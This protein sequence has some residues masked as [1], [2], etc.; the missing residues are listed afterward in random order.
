MGSRATACSPLHGAATGCNRTVICAGITIPQF[1][2]G[3]TRI[4]SRT[5][6]WYPFADTV[7][8]NIPAAILLL[9]KEG[10]LGS[11]GA[12]GVTFAEIVSSVVPSDTRSVRVDDG[13]MPVTASTTVILTDGVASAKQSPEQP[14]SVATATADA[15]ARI[16]RRSALA[17]SEFMLYSAL[18][19]RQKLKFEQQMRCVITVDSG[20]VVTCLSCAQASQRVRIG[21]WPT[22]ANTQLL[23]DCAQ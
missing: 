4:P 12:G 11:G 7:T 23:E 10:R 18:H 3:S 20:L 14:E 8:R 5:N 1:P 21:W 2:S 13:A 16:P 19:E 6:V 17:S 9:S 15:V 22:A